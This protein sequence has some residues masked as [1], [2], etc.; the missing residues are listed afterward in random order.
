MIADHLAERERRRTA[1]VEGAAST[2]GKTARDFIEQHK[3]PRTGQRPRR[4]REIG[5]ILGLHYPVDG[6]EPS[7]IRGGLAERWR[8]KPIAEIDGHDIHGV[9]D[10]ARRI[11]T[12][13]TPPRVSGTVRRARPQ[14]G[15]RAGHFVRLGDAAPA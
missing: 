2:F 4:W 9:V 14:D 13:G 1:V 3:V 8:E 15:R 5:C 11:G 6:G 7:E 10:E 12:P